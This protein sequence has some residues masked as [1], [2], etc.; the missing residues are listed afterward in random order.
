[1]IPSY[2]AVCNEFFGYVH[3]SEKVPLQ[4]AV[5]ISEFKELLPDCKFTP[6]FELNLLKY[7]GHKKVNIKVQEKM[8]ES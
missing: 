8:G 6:V 1:M 3:S 4:G 5:E 7:Y 2:S